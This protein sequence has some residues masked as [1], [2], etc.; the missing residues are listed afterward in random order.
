MEMKYFQNVYMQPRV[1]TANYAIFGQVNMYS[2][3]GK[4]VGSNYEY[5]LSTYDVTQG[6]NSEPP[7]NS[8]FNIANM[9]MLVSLGEAAPNI[10][11]E[12]N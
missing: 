8:L 3:N 12:S 5:L 2:G 4:T 6:E 10:L 11:T 7:S 1:G 9:Q